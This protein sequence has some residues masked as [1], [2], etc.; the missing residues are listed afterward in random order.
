[1]P[2]PSESWVG[3]Y[4]RRMAVSLERMYENALDWEHLPH[5]H[6]SSFSS[7]DLIEDGDWGWRARVGLGAPGD[8]G[9]KAENEILL[10]LSLD[11]TH[12][13]W[14]SATLE[15]PGKGSEIW[16]HVF[17]HGPRDIEIQA[18]FFVPGLTEAQKPAAATYYKA[19]YHRLY[20]EDEAMMLA[21]QA[22][23]DARSKNGSDEA[24]AQ[25]RITLGPVAPLMA[26]AKTRGA[27][28]FSL[29]GRRWALSFTDDTPR[30]HAADCPHLQLPL[31]NAHLEGTRL[32]CP[33]HGYQF[34]VE[35]GACLTGQSCRLPRPPSLLIE[36]DALIATLDE[37]S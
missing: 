21:R 17:E 28:T 9:S 1:M 15:G 24:S 16:T 22:A 32:T 36:G 6:G 4:Q 34:D 25:R 37:W 20:D 31:E 23:L 19:L 18:D 27:H 13:R 7:I 3:A 11:R 33:W 35:S 12:R 29:G 10:Q 26:E 8:P 14:I 5:L 2:G 30:I